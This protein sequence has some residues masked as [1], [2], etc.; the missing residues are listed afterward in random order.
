MAVSSTFLSTDA[1]GHYT[2]GKEQIN[3]VMDKVHCLVDNCTGL[4]G[5][6]V[7][8]SF[9]VGTSFDFSALLLEHLSMDYGKKLKLECTVY[10]APPDIEL[11]C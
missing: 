2:V 8:H 10:P 9:G 3:V 6:F 7:F 1:Y 11:Y 4:Q 5:F